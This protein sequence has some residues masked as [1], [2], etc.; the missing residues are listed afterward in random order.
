MLTSRETASSSFYT[1]SLTLL[2]EAGKTV[3]FSFTFTKTSN[4]IDTANVTKITVKFLLM[5]KVNLFNC[6]NLTFNY[7]FHL[8]NYQNMT[9]NYVSN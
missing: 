6:Q 8:K 9:T 4:L 2:L 1:I 3:K 7:L 5:I